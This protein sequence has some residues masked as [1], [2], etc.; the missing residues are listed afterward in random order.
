MSDASTASGAPGAPV[1][2][3]A[4]AASGGAGAVDAAAAETAP[5]AAQLA[6]AG[7]PPRSAGADGP[8]TGSS[9]LLTA[10]EVP[11]EQPTP[12]AAKKAKA[13]RRR[14]RRVVAVLTATAVLCAVGGGAAF[15]LSQGSGGNYRTTT[16]ELGTVDE[17]LALS[18]T[19]AAV[20]RHDSAFQVGGTVNGVS[21]SVGDTVTAGQ[22][23]A[24]LDTSD[25][26]DAVDGAH[27]AVTAAQEQLE[28][29]L[30]AQSSGSTSSSTSAGG[31]VGAGAS[32]DAAAGAGGSSGAAPSGGTGGAPSDGTGGDSGSGAGGSGTGGGSDSGSGGGSGTG[33]SAFDSTAIDTAVAAVKTAQQ[34]LLDQYAT[35]Q[36]A[37]DATQETIAS[38]DAACRPFLE[39]TIDD[40]VAGGG[41]GSSGG[42]S[43]EG[44]DA[45]DDGTDAGADTGGDTGTA[46]GSAALDAIKADLAAC[47]TAIGEVQTEQVAV[48]TSQ[49]TLLD[50][51]TALDDA[52]ASLQTAVA[53]AVAAAG[54]AGSAGGS[55]SGS[56]GSG[57]GSATP[58]PTPAPTTS[59]ETTAQ[60]A[61]A[62]ATTSSS[63]SRSSS[64]TAVTTVALVA[65]VDTG[66]SSG[67]SAAAA[68]GAGVSGTV[69]AETIVADQAEIEVAKSDLAI[70]QQQLTLATLTSPISGTV[71][72][73]S[74]AVGDTVT[75]AST[76]AVIT[77]LGD[78][79]YLVSTT[80]TL[81][82]VPK[83]A[84]GQSA[85]VSLAS[86]EGDAPLTGVVS[87]IGVLDVSSD[88]SSP[89]YDVVIA[90]DPTDQTLLTGA[91]AQVE[92]AVASQ[93]S[94]LT[95][96][97]SAVHRSGTDYTVDL[98]VDGASQPTPVEVGAMGAERTEVTSGLSEGDVVVLA[99]LDS[100]VLDSDSETG[101]SGLNG[102]GGS[103]STVTVPS[104]G[105]P[106][107]TSGFPAG[108][109]PT[110]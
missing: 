32:G 12:L 20:S 46:D 66:S 39:A 28:S 24:T 14:N 82:N 54:S 15:A 74:L 88:S 19:V 2:S 61:P 96:P 65:A 69:T 107:G 56:T 80:V 103:S 90:L 47:Q 59:A 106:G 6:V 45:A 89:S 3:G 7:V 4:P 13:R 68:G 25:L 38:S 84:V 99:D 70:A 76:S 93:A 87:S 77:V 42:S 57:G 91:S 10:S 83:L 95:V 18:G 71:A 109:P 43:D 22:Q 44:G 60:T 55:G 11:V 34:A 41:A 110:Q 53:D 36:A 26:Q 21:V 37:T 58:S 27:E 78:D 75:A 67:A 52:V 31:S 35:A 97:T 105:F 63:T 23:L 40:I 17:T 8:V 62:M 100:D 81:A 51:M 94:V 30:E 16:A 5:T 33:G 29:D 92:V 108:G 49:S 9:N 79:G 64:G 73:V 50:L 98:L 48:Q 101:S 85:S 72:A 1:A 102:L 86:G 104:G